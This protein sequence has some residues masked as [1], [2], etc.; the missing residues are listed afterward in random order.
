MNFF[1]R[2]RVQKDILDSIVYTDVTLTV[3]ETNPVIVSLEFVMKVVKTGGV[4][5]YVEHVSFQVCLE[6]WDVLIIVL[7]ELILFLLITEPLCKTK[8]YYFSNIF[9]A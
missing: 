3:V 8:S 2:Q 5:P 9:Q 1:P 7:C 6:L 4:T